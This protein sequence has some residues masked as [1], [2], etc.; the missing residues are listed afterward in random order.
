MRIDLIP[1]NQWHTISLQEWNHLSEVSVIPN[2]FYERWC[3][4][5]AINNLGGDLE[6]YIACGYD[7]GELQVLCP[8]VINKPYPFL[9]QVE[10][11]RHPHCSLS[12]PLI[13]DIEI[14]PEF[15]TCLLNTFSS[16]ILRISNHPKAEVARKEQK[17]HIIDRHQRAAQ[18]LGI[19]WEAYLDQHLGRKQLKY[20]KILNRIENNFGAKYQNVST[21]NLTTWLNRFV[22]VESTG[23][24]YKAGTSLSQNDG[25]LGYYSDCIKLGQIENKI[26][27]QSIV[28]Q[29]HDIAISFRFVTH[30]QCFE[31]KTSYHGDFKKYS[32]GIALE[33]YNLKDMFEGGCEYADSCT[34][35]DNAVVNR[36]WQQ[37]R[38]LLSAV[39]FQPSIQGRMIFKG[40]EIVKRIRS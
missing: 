4:G 26:E 39:F 32:P 37:R 13:S 20:K 15:L 35:E 21:G 9:Q 6:I 10:V 36:L 23:W 1:A 3:L 16:P 5:P 29:S 34:D 8:V 31:I 28:S 30:N 12:S 11:W 14:L 24:K 40:F 19:T 18:D 7:D 38:E 2:P 17:N 25:E 22:V 33:L 27:F